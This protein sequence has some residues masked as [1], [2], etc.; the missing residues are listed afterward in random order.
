MSDLKCSSCGCACT[1]EE[2]P[3]E[4]AAENTSDASQ[5]YHTET[6]FAVL[7]ALV[8]AMTMSVFNL[9]GVLG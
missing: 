1:A 4:A 2:M 8:P 6:Q 3:V 7:L 9:T 5:D